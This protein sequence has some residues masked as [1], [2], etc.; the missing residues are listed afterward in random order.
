MIIH[1]PQ[2]KHLIGLSMIGILELLKV[3]AQGLHY[4][5][6]T[7]ALWVLIAE[8]MDLNLAILTK[9]HFSDGLMF[10]GEEM[11]RRTQD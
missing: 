8:E 4:S 11:E 10:R 1:L 6:L 7:N 9:V 3:E 5:V 2:L